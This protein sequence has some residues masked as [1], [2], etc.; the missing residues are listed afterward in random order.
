[1]KSPGLED[2]W[3]LH[4]AVAGGKETNVPD[5]FIA[6]VDE[7]CEASYLKLTAESNGSFTVFNSRNKFQKI[8]KADK[9]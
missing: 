1:M 6:N 3:Q 8:Y 9:R 4:F 7:H 5:P 2:M